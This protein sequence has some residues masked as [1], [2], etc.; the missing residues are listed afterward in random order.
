MIKSLAILEPVFG[1]I[2]PVTP[3][4]LAILTWPG[5]ARLRWARQ[6]GQAEGRSM[7]SGVDL[8]NK[9]FD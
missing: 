6:M 4:T 9:C 5:L 3:T 2:I 1:S 8:Y 7:R